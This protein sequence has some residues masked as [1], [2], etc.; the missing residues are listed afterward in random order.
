MFLKYTMAAGLVA[1]SMIAAVPANAFEKPSGS[2]TIQLVQDYGSEHEWGER[3]SL[4]PRALRRALRH[5]GYRNIEILDRGRRTVTV[6]AENYRGRDYIL[7]V[8][9]RSGAVISARRIRNWQHDGRDDDRERCWL[10]EG[11]DD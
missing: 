4:S 6:Q 9:A 1:L 3:R 10:P 2:A 11:C 8:S 7:R 5:Q